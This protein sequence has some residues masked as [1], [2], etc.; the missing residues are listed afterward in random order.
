MLSL[1]L[2]ENVE[3]LKQQQASRVWKR[4]CRF[5]NLYQDRL[6]DFLHFILSFPHFLSIFAMRSMGR[7]G[8]HI[9]RKFQLY[10]LRKQHLITLTLSQRKR[11]REIKGGSENVV[12]DK[13]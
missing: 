11:E 12:F 1:I 2:G 8:G 9:E 13:E 3:Q 10:F 7:G 6:F 4:N 5:A